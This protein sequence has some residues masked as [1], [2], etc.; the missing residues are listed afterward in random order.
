MVGINPK[1]NNMLSGYMEAKHQ[2]I[3]ISDSNIKSEEGGR[4]GQ[5][6][7]SRRREG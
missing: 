2:F 1:I 7:S 5:R 3:W 4:E 6:A